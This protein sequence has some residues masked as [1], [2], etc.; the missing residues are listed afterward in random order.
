MN[1]ADPE[2]PQN[3]NEEESNQQVETNLEENKNNK[4]STGL[5]ENVASLIT[6]VAGFVSGII[7][8]I[9]EKENK[10]VRFHAIQSIALTVSYFILNFVFDYVPF[11]GWLLNV[12]LYPAALVLWIVC[13]VQAYQG[14]KF[15]IPVLGDLADQ[16]K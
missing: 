16:Y 11:I 4:T 13:M 7:L 15:K 1:Q 6:Y 8:L 3:E 2:D 5:A 12:L 10:V 14:R 9:L